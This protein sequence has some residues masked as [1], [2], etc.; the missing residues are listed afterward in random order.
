MVLALVLVI[1]LACGL[2]IFIQFRRFEE[3]HAASSQLLTAQT[4][5]EVAKK[6]LSGYT[7]VDN[8]LAQGKLKLLEQAPSFCVSVTRDYV[9]QERF[10][11]D[12]DKLTSDVTLTARSTVSFT[13]SVNL[14]SG[15]FEVAREALGIR[16]RVTQ[17][18]LLGTPNVKIVSHE[19]TATGV[20]PD[21]RAALADIQHKFTSLA[22]SSA[23]AIG[24]EDTVRALFK[25]KLIDA[26][27][28]FLAAQ[29]GVRHVPFI[30]VEFQ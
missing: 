11:R 5:L 23:S 20:L 1:G 8:Y 25:V 17:P 22:M 3:Q 13:F 24:R 12:K 2:L 19:V 29:A 10:S 28:V 18:G 6:A 21:E 9:H 15:K 16:I 27:H 4:E 26:L 7:K 14:A 30:G